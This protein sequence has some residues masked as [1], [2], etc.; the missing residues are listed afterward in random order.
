MSRPIPA[1]SP[2]L[3]WLIEETIFPTNLPAESS[4][5]I[6]IFPTLLNPSASAFAT[7]GI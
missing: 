1:E 5:Y 6:V 2:S 3:S 4:P 7:C